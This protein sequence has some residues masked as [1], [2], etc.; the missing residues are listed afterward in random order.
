MT[1]AKEI[2]FL[3]RARTG[4][5]HTLAILDAAGKLPVSDIADLDTL[6]GAARDLC[7]RHFEEIDNVIDALKAGGGA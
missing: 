4:L 1:T 7:G 5:L 2:A 3:E 6:L